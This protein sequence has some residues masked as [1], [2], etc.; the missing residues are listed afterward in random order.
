MAKEAKHFAIVVG[1][2]I[3]YLIIR[4]HYINEI[5]GNYESAAFLKG[6]YVMLLRNYA[7]LFVRSF[8]PA[9]INNKL[10]TRLL[11]CY[12]DYCRISFFTTSKTG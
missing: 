7:I 1:I 8:L 3:F 5:T 4:W 11:W 12:W 10:L 2:F 9:F 6:D